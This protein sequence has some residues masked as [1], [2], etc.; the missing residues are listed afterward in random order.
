MSWGQPEILE[1][2]ERLARAGR[3]VQQWWSQVLQLGNR[4]KQ[5]GFP[6]V[7]PWV[8]EAPFDVIGDHLRGTRGIMLDL[9]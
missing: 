2:V 4:L 6:D 5:H 3:E 8:A 7:T 1:S 9:Y